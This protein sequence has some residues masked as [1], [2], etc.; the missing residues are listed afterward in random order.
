MRNIALSDGQSWVEELIADLIPW[1][2]GSERGRDFDFSNRPTSPPDV[3]RKE[4]DSPFIGQP[5]V[6]RVQFHRQ[7]VPLPATVWLML[8]GLGVCCGRYRRKK[9]HGCLAEAN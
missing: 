8:G 2:A 7:A 3:I 6:A 5:A 9:N 1:D 4:F